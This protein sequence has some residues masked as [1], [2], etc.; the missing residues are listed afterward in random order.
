M[1]L[2]LHHQP[3]LATHTHICLVVEKNSDLP[4]RRGGTTVL[5]EDHK[6]AV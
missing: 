2:H 3:E 6:E 1:T 5:G 4:I